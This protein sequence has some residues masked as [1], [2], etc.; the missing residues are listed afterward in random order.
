MK[1]GISF[2]HKMTQKLSGQSNLLAVTKEEML[3]H[4]ILSFISF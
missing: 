1:D 3:Y 2:H 4:L